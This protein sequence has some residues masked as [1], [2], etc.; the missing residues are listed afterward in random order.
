MLVR[1]V[2]MADRRQFL[3]VVAVDD[4]A[5]PVQQQALRDFARAM[6]AFYD[7]GA[8]QPERLGLQPGP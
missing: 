7:P 8:P 6:A 2:R 4:V 1:R 5:V 3:H